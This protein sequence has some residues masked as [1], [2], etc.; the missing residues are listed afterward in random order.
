MKIKLLSILAFFAFTAQAQWGTD[1]VVSIG[2]GYADQVWY[3]L[4]NDEQGTAPKNNWDLAFEINGFTSSIRVNGAN[5]VKVW[6][7]PNGDTTDWAT[8]DTNGM[9]ANWPM[10]YNSDTSWSYGAL[11][12]G[13]DFNNQFDMGWGVYNMT[14]HHVVGD[15]LFVIQLNDNT[16]RKLW[17]E[18]LASGSYT[19]RYA[20]LDN[21]GDV[22]ETLAK[23]DYTDRNFGYY[24]IESQQ[25]LD[26]EPN[27]MGWD[28]LFTQYGVYFPSFNYFTTSTGVLQNSGV[29]AAKAYP[30]NDSS[31]YEDYSAHTLSQEINTI[32]YE[33]KTFDM[34]TFTYSID[35]S[36]VY[37]VKAK[38]GDY[39]KMVFTGFGGSTT[40]DME[41]TKKK[42]GSVGIN[43]FET[44]SFVQVYPNPSQTNQ[45]I[46]LVLDS[47]NPENIKVNMIDL[48]GRIVSKQ[49][50]NVQPG[51][52]TYT[53]TAPAIAGQYILQVAGQ[54]IH[55][56]T[57]IIIK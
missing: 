28:L 44:E 4:E 15:S 20:N 22:S 8:L 24:S 31:T 21:S 42:L 40:G 32:G 57:K 9:A 41:F 43:E 33:W 55:T 12:A 46:S 10:Y 7:Y 23:S 35:D 1:D 51:L 36:T 6:K 29:E 54:N 50:I 53:I 25:E 56:T 48:S 38:N 5:D 34:G 27:N 2:S 11:N 17:I 13:T 45:N 19:F 52:N 14:T 30:V 3:S 47:K 37:F 39:W 26:R 49:N 16:Y 18:R